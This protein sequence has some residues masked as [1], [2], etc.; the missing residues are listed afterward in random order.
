MNSDGTEIKEKVGKLKK[1]LTKTKRFLCR[2][3]V[4]KG[5]KISPFGA[6]ADSLEPYLV[7]K[8]G[9]RVIKDKKISKRTGTNPDFYVYFD[10]D[11]RLPGSCTIRIEIWNDDPFGF[12]DLIGYTEIDVENRYFNRKWMA[13]A[14]K[15]VESRN[16]KPEFSNKSVGRLN[17]ILELLESVKIKPYDISPL[18]QEPYELR[19]VVWETMDCVIKDEVLL[20]LSDRL[21]N[22]YID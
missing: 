19:V 11:V 17:L 21:F 22:K 12:D 4:L 1:V 15:P 18:K 8:C 7:I 14:K 20:D 5:M 3:Y 13:K 10:F 9:D 6:S 16:I 2:L